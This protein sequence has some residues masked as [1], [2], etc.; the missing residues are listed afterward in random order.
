M[1]DTACQVFIW[2][3]LLLRGGALLGI[4]KLVI[5][6][7][8]KRLFSKSGKAVFKVLKQTLDKK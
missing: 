4:G 8:I 7:I 1:M 2:F 3:V 5:S 6:C